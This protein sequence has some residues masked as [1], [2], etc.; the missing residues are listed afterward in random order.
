MG[1]RGGS[2]RWLAIDG[3]RERDGVRGAMREGHLDVDWGRPEDRWVT[4][5]TDIKVGSRAGGGT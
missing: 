3:G 5:W 4:I 2:E 1:D